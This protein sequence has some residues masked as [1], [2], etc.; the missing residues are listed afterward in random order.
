MNEKI[1]SIHVDKEYILSYI[2]EEFSV[3]LDEITDVVIALDNHLLFTNINNGQHTHDL[4]LRIEGIKKAIKSLI[5]LNTNEHSYNECF[6][7]CDLGLTLEKILPLLK[8]YA[9]DKDVVINSSVTP[10]VKI[11]GN[12][13]QLRSVFKQLLYLLIKEFVNGGTIE[14]SAQNE[15]HGIVIT[16]NIYGSM[17]F[18]ITNQSIIN[19]EKLFSKKTTWKTQATKLFFIYNTLKQN[20]SKMTIYKQSPIHRTISIILPTS[21][22]GIIQ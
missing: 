12:D 4:R 18:E 9:Q 3:L 11:Y 8:I 6:D 10:P 20:R 21:D 22:S 7:L 16:I 17:R 15:N 19:L 13:N 5:D 1:K 2:E 14:L